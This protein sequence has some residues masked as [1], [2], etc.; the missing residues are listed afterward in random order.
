MLEVNG[1]VKLLASFKTDQ[2]WIR[3]ILQYISLNGFGLGA[4]GESEGNPAN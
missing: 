3:K 1:E 4:Y 2:N